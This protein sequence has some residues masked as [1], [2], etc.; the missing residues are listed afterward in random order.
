MRQFYGGLFF[1]CIVAFAHSALAADLPVKA[2]SASPVATWTGFYLGATAGYGQAGDT[3]RYQAVEPFFYGGA[4][5]RGEIPGR[6][7]AEGRGFIGGIT[8][9]YNY[10]PNSAY[11]VG[12]ETD[13]SYSDIKGTKTFV[14]TPI[15][16]DPTITTR[17]VNRLNWLGTARV[18]GGVLVTSSLLAYASGG[19]AYGG[20]STETHTSVSPGLVGAP[21][22]C[23]PAG[24]IWCGDGSASKVMFGWTA[25]AGL[26]QALPN[27]WS[28]KAEYLYYDLG[29][30]SYDHLSQSP[31]G[32]LA[33]SV[34]SSIRGH[35]GRI[36]LNYKFGPSAQ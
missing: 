4:I 3:A 23:G 6:L 28:A 17:Q 10:Q 12:F 25:G 36:G 24:N 1:G 5:L 34:D 8:A 18:R 19:L 9:G 33:M 22:F 26:E 31:A 2:N 20:V 30:V 15:L 35:I 13:I 11:A 27:G 21:P 29:R 7:D 32:L 16:F 14:S